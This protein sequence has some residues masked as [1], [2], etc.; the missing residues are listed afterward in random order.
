VGYSRDINSMRMVWRAFRSQRVYSICNR[1]A[2]LGLARYI[3]IIKYTKSGNKWMPG[4]IY[5]YL[6]PGHR[7][8]NY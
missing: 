1:L 8:A 2:R 4:R 3:E 6:E 7:K 5:G